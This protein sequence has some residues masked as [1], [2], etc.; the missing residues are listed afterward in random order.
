MRKNFR[1]YYLAVEFYR[2][3]APLKLPRHL[4]DQ[5]LRASSSIV[6][7]LSEG[8][9]KRTRKDQRKYFHQ[10]FGSLRETQAI[11]DLAPNEDCKLEKLA[12][13]LAAHVYR[14]IKS[15]EE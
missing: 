13:I 6:L 8:S 2:E 5:L 3:C 10:A 1:T 15:C 9:G 12:D 11:F 14:L 4:K 7:N